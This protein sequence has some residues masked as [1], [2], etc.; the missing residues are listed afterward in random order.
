[1]GYELVLELGQKVGQLISKSEEKLW[2]IDIKNFTV[3]PLDQIKCSPSLEEAVAKAEGSRGELVED[4][5]VALLVVAVVVSVAAQVQLVQVD[6]VP[7]EHARQELVPGDVLLHRRDDPPT[8][9]V[10]RLVGPLRVQPA[11]LLHDLNK[12]QEEQRREI[13]PRPGEGQHKT[14]TEK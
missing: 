11:Q 10:Q 6:G 3:S 4:G 14:S 8:L 9:L 2:D 5:G 12:G 7:A 13:K 1:M